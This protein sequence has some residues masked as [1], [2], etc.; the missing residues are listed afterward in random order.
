ME[1][2]YN[3]FKFIE[4][5]YPQYKIPSVL[6]II[7]NDPLTEEDLNIERDL[8]LGYNIYLTSLPDGLEVGRNLY[9]N[10]CTSLTSL[11]D[12]LTVGESLDLSDCI[13]LT[14]L[15]EGLEVGRNLNLIGCANLKSLPEGLYVGRDLSLRSTLIA[16]KYTEAEI[17]EM[18]PRIRGNIYL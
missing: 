17:R 16:K 2:I 13:S 3:L 14:S 12:G 5:R 7:N 1:K 15:P 11:P 6:K 9:L 4:S 18:C 10:D 8:D